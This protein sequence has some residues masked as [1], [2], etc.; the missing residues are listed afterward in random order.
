MEGTQT[1]H[2]QKAEVANARPLNRW[3][4]LKGLQISIWEGAAATVWITLTG[5]AFLTG[6]AIWLHADS[7]AIGLL[8]AIPTLAALIQPIAAYWAE[9]KS[10]R[11]PFVAWC[12]FCGRML[13]LPILLLP[14]LLPKSLALLGFLLL[15]TLSSILTSMPQ[16]VWTSWMSDL[17][18][19]DHRGRYFGR[20]NMVAGF[21][22]M[23]V[24]MLAAWF[25]DRM[26]HRRHSAMGFAVIFGVSL[27][28]AV[29]SLI[30]ILR[31]PEPPPS[32]V[33]TQGE[34]PRQSFLDHYRAPFA[35][36]NF[37]A[38]LLFS[39]VFCIGQFV[40]APFFT[41]YGLQILHLN[42]VW[43]QILA[44]VVGVSNMLGMPLW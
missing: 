19:P 8:S 3:E 44:A 42:Y 24:G 38:L 36:P 33:T 28:G 12:S 11:K 29:L 5:G 17:V 15:F 21:V 37:R 14:F 22:G 16:P 9:Q 10:A 27:L 23:V 6:F 34:E 35:D 18:P 1:Q 32:S 30:L 41:A 39:T 7:F 26:V 13:W 40:A 25:L 31:Q 20:R 43:M 4:V 2:V